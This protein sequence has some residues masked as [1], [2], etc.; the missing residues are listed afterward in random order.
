M[1]LVVGLGNPG[2]EYAASRH[3]VGFAVADELVARHRIATEVRFHGRFGETAGG[4]IG[5]FGVLFPHTWMNASGASV[6]AA[7]EVLGLDPARELIV[8]CDDLDLPPG[9]LRLRP[10]GGSGGHRGL[11][12]IGEALG[13]GEFPRLRFG[14]GRPPAGSDVVEY[15]LAAFASGEVAALAPA[16]R[17][18]ADAVEC[19]F[20]DGVGVA[21]E[22]YNRAVAD[23]VEEDPAQ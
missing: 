2:A 13:H 1:K 17:R 18:A 19:A 5:R 15:V 9:R 3:N 10:R 16:I 23:T 6:R 4:G 14:I 21:M 12:S 8:V 11:A 7:V 22:R 20:S